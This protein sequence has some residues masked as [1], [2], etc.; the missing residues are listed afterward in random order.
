[1][2]DE[3]DQTIGSSEMPS[4]EAMLAARRQIE[5]EDEARYDRATQAPAVPAE[6]KRWDGVVGDTEAGLDIPPAIP[7]IAAMLATL[8][9][10]KLV[11]R[12]SGRAM[13]RS[14]AGAPAMVATAGTPLDRI[15]AFTS[16][17][18]QDLNA[19]AASKRVTAPIMAAG[20]PLHGNAYYKP[21]SKLLKA[22]VRGNPDA[23]RE[24]IAALRSRGIAGGLDEHIGLGINS[25]P[26]AMH[27]IGH[28]T[29][30]FGSTRLRNAVQTLAGVSRSPIGGAARMLMMAN[31]L[32][33]QKDEESSLR[34]YTRDN[35]PALIAASAAPYVFEEAR[36]NT[37]ALLGARK[38]GPG[39]G[40]AA[41]QL[42]PAFGTYV[43]AAAAPV[44]AT[45]AAQKLMEYLRARGQAQQ[46]KQA[47]PTAGKEVQAPG[48]LRA[49]ASAAWRTGLS[50]PKP[51]STKPS[52]GPGQRAKDIPT[53]RPPGKT[54]FF[55]DMVK[56]LN[57]PQRGFRLA[58]LQG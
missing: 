3:E 34:T 41:R 58:K 32:S 7:S 1:M 56:T 6:R 54:G 42:L 37:H 40:A 57:N 16:K 49:S 27:E 30:I 33:A 36:A 21:E 11:R 38:Y 17:E 48:I 43:A 35:A 19:F 4:L 22:L 24:M 39:V 18:V 52:T 44:L 45:I 2:N 13:Q 55:S 26:V 15:A 28:A 5:A 25:V 50:A 51:K 20:P 46:E 12:A 9:A 31:A 23:E 47:A 14:V 29:P 8:H 53:A 10:G